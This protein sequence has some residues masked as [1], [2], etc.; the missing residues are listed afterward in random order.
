MRTGARS[1]TIAAVSETP[2][3]SAPG[4][5]SR[6]S[7]RDA[8]L[9]ALA[10]AAV[11]VA[12]R[13]WGLG[14]ESLWLDEGFT[15]R[16]TQLP[17]LAVIAASRQ[18]V[19]PPL[20]PLLVGAVVRLFGDCE[21][22]L[23]SVSVAG[24]C[25]AVFF[26]WRLARRA[27]GPAAAW[28]AAA[29]VALSAFQVRY[30]QEARP[31]ALFGGLAL[32]SAD[33]LLCSLAGGRVRARVAWV[34]A[35]TALVYTHAHGAFVVLAEALAVAW[36]MRSAGGRRAAR[37]MAV[38]AAAVLAAFLPWAFV[39]GEQA[40]RVIRAFWIAHPAPFDLVRTLYEFAGSAT[41]LA[42]LGALAAL[43]LARPAAPD[44][45]HLP[46]SPAPP[47]PARALVVSLALV[48]LLVPFA[49]S[50]AG[51]A[52]YLTRASIA[53]S[54]ALAILAATGW[55]GLPARL[56]AFVAVV[57][58]AACVPPL[59]A[60][61]RNV[62]KEPWRDAVAWLEREAQPGDLVLVT[63]PWY[64]DGVFAYY[65][66]RRD[67]DVRPAPLHEGPVTLA[68]IEALSTTLAQHPRAWLVR[69]RT[70]DPEELLPAA[71]AAG[72]ER[73]AWRE[74]LVT[75]PGLTRTHRV[76]AFDVFCYAAPAFSAPPVSPRPRGR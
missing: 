23:R 20:F 34:A 29:L 12:L 75:P 61:Q 22:T 74:W 48:P 55:A 39:L 14:R 37:V 69:A 5:T 38:P 52:V 24:S 30:A 76:R 18:D 4:V 66:K 11:A 19:H 43:G 63:A 21:T 13:V 72:R 57:A 49:I 26:A 32:A 3:P 25:A 64:R 50:L 73:V 33:A 51:P 9:A 17:P 10:L 46:A 42:L 70:E 1:G 60:L 27:F 67:L 40:R 62:Y 44:A 7:R 71:L 28:G 59:V 2:L 58:I 16:L 65:A 8:W 53:S 54:L 15:W 56:R 35:T 6:S 47:P 41:L 31:Y 36:W 68:D 45:D